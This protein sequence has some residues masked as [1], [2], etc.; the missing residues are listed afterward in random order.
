MLAGCRP[1]ELGWWSAGTET[2]LLPGTSAA[3]QLDL[4]PRP[5]WGCVV[6]NL[7]LG[8][9]GTHQLEDAAGPVS[10]SVRAH[11]V[12]ILL[13]QTRVSFTCVCTLCAT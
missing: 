5:V 6:P 9:A 1:A 7:L 12:C 11:R 4:C 10:P 3:P 13:V 8:I 2:A